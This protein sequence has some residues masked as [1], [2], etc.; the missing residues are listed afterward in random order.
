MSRATKR[1][2]WAKCIAVNFGVQDAVEAFDYSPSTVKTWIRQMKR[3]EN[4]PQDFEYFYQ[5]EK[6]KNQKLE[7]ENKKLREMLVNGLCTED[8][9]QTEKKSLFKH[10][11]GNAR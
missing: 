2:E 9:E 5:L 4:R 3:E 6:D 10:L 1:R 11:F 7:T 8:A